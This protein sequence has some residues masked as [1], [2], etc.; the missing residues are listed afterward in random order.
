MPV[1]GSLAFR[2]V[3]LE[4]NLWTVASGRRNL[5]MIVFEIEHVNHKGRTT[6]TMVNRFYNFIWSLHFQIW[7]KYGNILA[8]K[9]DVNTGSSI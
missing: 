6:F 8:A 9:L 5:Q 2:A 1:K 3:A 7:N 4:N